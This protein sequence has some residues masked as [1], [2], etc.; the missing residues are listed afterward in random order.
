MNKDLALLSG[1][2]C[3]GYSGFAIMAINWL[4]SP[5]I[6]YTAI[7]SLMLC[8]SCP[9]KYIATYTSVSIV[10]NKTQC[11]EICGQQYDQDTDPFQPDT[12]KK[13]WN[14]AHARS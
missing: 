3:L 4:F 11:P 6:S 9:A 13:I 12:N 5:D 10:K 14:N 8:C 2:F 7:T 1:F